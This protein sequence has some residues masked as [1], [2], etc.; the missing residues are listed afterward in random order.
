MSKKSKSAPSKPRPKAAQLSKE[1]Q[2][3]LSAFV[4]SSTEGFALLDE[5]L[6]YM[7]I[8]PV[9]ERIIGVSREAVVGKNILDVVPDVKESGRYDK[10]VNILETGEPLHI[11]DMVSHTKFRDIHASLKAFR[12]ENW[13]GLV[14][15]DT[16]ERKQ[17]EE[18]LRQ[19]EH[20]YR[21]LF[22][23]TLD[24]LF[25]VNAETGKIVLANRTAA[26]IFGFDSPEAMIGMDPINFFNPNDRNGV[27][28][29]VAED[30]LRD[31]SEEGARS[32]REVREVRVI[33]NDGGEIW[34]EIQGT[35]TEYQGKLAYLVSNKDITERKQAEE[36]IQSLA[37]FPSENPCPVLRVEKDGKVLYSNKAGLELLDEWKMKIGEKVPGEWCRLIEEAFESGQPRS[38]EEEVKDKIFSLDIAL[39]KESGYVNL[40]GH[41]ITERRE[42]EEA[43][44]ESEQKYQD[45]FNTAEVALFRS[46]IAD[47][48]ILECNDL[49]A[50]LFG[51]DSREQCM[52][53]HVTSEHYVDHSVRAQILTQMLENGK[54][55]NFEALVMR[56]DGSPF[57]ISYSAHI[58]PE[59]NFIEGAIVDITERKRM[60]EQ[61]RR[62]SHDLDLLSKAAMSLVEL[63]SDADIHRFIAER[64]QEF[65]EGAAVLVNSCDEASDTFC[66]REALGIGEQMEALTGMLGC[67][68]IGMH[69]PTGDE[70]KRSPTLGELGKVQG[71]TYE[72]ASG[73]IPMPVC[74]EIEKLLDIGNVYAIGLTWE[75]RLYGS[76]V[77]LTGNGTELR[78][79]DVIETFVRQASIALQRRQA[80]EALKESEERYRALVEAAGTSGEGIMIVQDTERREGA[81]V[82]V[83]DE[84]CRMS[85]FSREEVLNKTAW[86]ITSL[87]IGSELWDRYKRRQRSETMPSHYE[88]VGARKDGALLPVEL[89]L[90]LTNWQGKIATVVYARDVTE[91]KRMEDALRKSEQTIRQ[92]AKAST[93]THEEERQRVSLEVHDRISQTLTGA[94]HQLQ[95][96]EAIPIENT[97][98]QQILKRASALLKESIRESR[99][100]IEDLYSPV[101][102]DFGIVAVIDE[103][104]RR[105]EE[106]TGCRT[107]FDK[108][109]AV[110]PTPDAELT[111]YRIFREV[112]ANIKRHAIGASEVKVSFSCEAGVVSLQV[113]DNGPGFDVEAA[114]QNGRMGGLKGMQR[115]AE[116]GGGACEVVSS[117][118][119]GTTVTV[120][121]PY[122][123]EA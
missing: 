6:N 83:N 26:K 56:K 123:S 61:E 65:A 114:L 54:V 67:D 71:G 88:V 99:N 92:L 59:R 16:T 101:L 97:E 100:I 87:D 118:G 93:S 109:F 75:G 55:E 33:T 13:L 89:S 29:F 40:Y 18:A 42:A 122:S 76:A 35:P 50:K 116:L 79:K 68:L 82:F 43:L 110:R 39:I 1:V 34:L 52:A 46:R 70:W 103:E 105:F 117:R 98:A 3:R 28:K 120:R 66:V 36:E 10:Y 49:L 72:L 15:T 58:Y 63:P 113:K 86:D 8:N 115:R 7:I 38:E 9:A 17:A 94:F 5:N 30:V 74:Q 81:V 22:E 57:W 25:V 96:L 19:S 32:D 91:R 47:G 78:N 4:N 106:E 80:E 95:A 20:N 69:V 111:A 73:A 104:L 53:E 44:R 45:L 62:H 108:R 24:G 64:L 60:E 37:K 11:E 85:G 119:H 121:L 14:F 2:A 77:I 51:Y 41:D 84:F 90:A 48:K 23:G 12:V 31:L 107:K 21:V 102:S 112:L 27:L